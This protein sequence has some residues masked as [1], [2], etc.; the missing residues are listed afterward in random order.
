MR[1]RWFVNQST[2]RI[3]FELIAKWSGWG[4]VLMFQKSV[5]FV[6]FNICESAHYSTYQSTVQLNYSRGW[7]AMGF[8]PQG[9]MT[10]SD[11]AIMWADAGGRANLVVRKRQNLNKNI[12]VA[13]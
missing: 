12:S 13:N 10:G 2:Q 4:K 1:L 6:T 8:S 3:Q 5:H 7:M 9:A 11:L